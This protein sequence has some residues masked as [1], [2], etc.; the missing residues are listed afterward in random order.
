MNSNENDDNSTEEAQGEEINIE[1]QDNTEDSVDEVD[2]GAKRDIDIEDLEQLKLIEELKADNDTLRDEVKVQKA[3]YLRALADFENFK[4]RSIK[5]RSELLRYEGERILVDVLDVVDNFE[6]ALE[7][8]DGEQDNLRA[9]MEMIHNQFNDVLKK[10]DVLPKECVNEVFDP[11]IAN[12]LSIVEVADAEP[13][14]VV[15]EFKKAYTY[16]GK[17]IRQGEVVVA[18]GSSPKTEEEDGDS[19]DSDS[20]INA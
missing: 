20:G 9:G 11:N 18:K 7:H 12:A 5:E 2:E 13:N 8:K 16:K 3:N 1:V 14:T 10:W 17:L 19:G 6:R 15:E 4:K